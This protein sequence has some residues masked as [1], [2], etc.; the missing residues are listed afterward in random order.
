M[1]E[2]ERLL[3][4]PLSYEQLVKYVKNDHS[5]EADLQLNETTRTI[6]ADL[7]EALEIGILP[8]VAKKHKN[9]LYFT[10]WTLILKS[11]NRMVGDL[12]F[13]G[14]PNTKGEIEIGYGTYDDF[15]GKGYMTEAV[16]GMIKWAAT[17]PGVKYML[18]ETEKTNFASFRVLERNEFKMVQE[19]PSLLLWRRSVKLKRLKPESKNV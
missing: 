9:H 7:L 13:K 16:G 19:F 5:L 4:L 3:L 10:L 1:I 2:T 15:Q 18:A 8:S 11:E 12:C 14:E 17:Q 6:S